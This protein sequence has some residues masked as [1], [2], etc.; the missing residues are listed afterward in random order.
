MKP[1]ADLSPSR[2]RGD[3]RGLSGGARSARTSPSW[4]TTPG[5]ALC[6]LVAVKY[7][8]RIGRL[9]LTPA[10][11]YENFPPPAFRPLRTIALAPALVFVLVQSMR[12]ARARRLPIAYGW[13]TK[14]PRI[15]SR[16]RWLEPARQSA[17]DQA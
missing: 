17:R 3:H 12:P 10:D 5:G 15:R 16:H 13:V 7:P 9:V 8:E 11:A 6:Q 1:G 4:A 2:P 14:R